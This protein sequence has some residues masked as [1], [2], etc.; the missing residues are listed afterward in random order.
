MTTKP[1]SA[2]TAIQSVFAGSR[3]LSAR[4]SATN[5]E[6]SVRSARSR[7]NR[8]AATAPAS[9]ATARSDGWSTGGAI[10]GSG[11][12][13]DWSSTSSKRITPSRPPAATASDRRLTQRQIF[14][15]DSVKEVPRLIPV[16]LGELLAAARQVVVRIFLQHFVE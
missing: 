14:Y 10:V 4:A 1:A 11:I 9:A 5:N 12:G 6:T 8:G 15:I 13:T 7:R 16:A 2:D 3:G